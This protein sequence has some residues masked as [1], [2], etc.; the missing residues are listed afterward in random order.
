MKDYPFAVLLIDEA[1]KS[2]IPVKEDMI[3]IVSLENLKLL[4]LNM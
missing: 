2:L 3:S 4:M 1:N